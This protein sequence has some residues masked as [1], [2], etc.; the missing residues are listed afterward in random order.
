MWRFEHQQ[1]DEYKIFNVKRGG[2]LYS[3]VRP[4]RVG[5]RRAWVKAHADYNNDGDA[6]WRIKKQPDGTFK[7]INVKWGC[8]LYCSNVRDDD[9]DHKAWGKKSSTYNEGGNA[10]WEIKS[11]PRDQKVSLFLR[12]SANNDET[13]ENALRE[14]LRDF[15][16]KSHPTERIWIVG[17]FDAKA[18]DLSDLMGENEM[19]KT[20]L[21]IARQVAT[22]EYQGRLSVSACSYR[23]GIDYSKAQLDRCRERCG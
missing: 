23:F 11:V 9:G 14:V 15:W 17:F 10:L 13:A 1:G 18:G 16:A 8:V 6:L 19:W 12:S 21:K 5:D 22:D 20:V 4:D 2:P 3:A 7:L